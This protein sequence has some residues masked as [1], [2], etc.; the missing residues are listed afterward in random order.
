[1]AAHFERVNHSG[2]PLMLLLRLHVPSLPPFKNYRDLIRHLLR[3]MNLMRIASQTVKEWLKLPLTLGEDLC[4]FLL[5]FSE[6][7]LALHASFVGFSITFVI[8][9][10]AFLT[11][12]AYGHLTQSS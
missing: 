8:T 1:L 11:T 3:I 7:Q 4:S 10:G 2:V 12:T 9:K 6:F 5:S